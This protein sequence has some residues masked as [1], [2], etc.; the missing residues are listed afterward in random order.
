MLGIDPHL[1]GMAPAS[2]SRVFRKMFL[3]GISPTPEEIESMNREQQFAVNEA[4]K[5]LRYHVR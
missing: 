2:F 5:V 4:K 1:I 3:E